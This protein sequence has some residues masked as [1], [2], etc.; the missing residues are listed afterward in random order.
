MIFLLFAVVLVLSANNSGN[1]RK[2]K[3]SPP[4]LSDNIDKNPF[5]RNNI[6]LPVLSDN[7]N[8]NLFLEDRAT[9]L[10]ENWSNPFLSYT[11]R[12]TLSPSS[13]NN[14]RSQDTS[15]YKNAVETT[16]PHSVSVA[17][18][19]NNPF[20][21][22][23][24]N[25]DKNV[26]RMVP[27]INSNSSTSPWNEKLSTPNEIFN[28][29]TAYTIAERKSEQ[30]CQE[31]GR[32]IS[33]TTGILPL[34][35][36]NQ[37][38]IKVTN[39]NCINTNRL[40]IGGVTA[41]PGEFPHMVALGIKYSDGTFHVSC[42]GTLIA[43]EWVLSAAHCTYQPNP[44]DARIGFHD[45]RDNQHG[46]TTTISKMIRHP[47]YKPPTIYNDIALIKLSTVITFNKDI[48]PACLYQEYDIVP[49]QAWVSGWGVTEFEAEER[50]NQLQKA[51]LDIIDNLR[52]AIRHTQSIKIPYGITP[53][54]ICA[55]DPRGGWS[56]DTCQ[57][58]SGGPLQIVHPTNLCLFQILGITS[59]GQGCAF[60]NMPG[61]YT[62]VP[63]YLNWIEDIVW[64][65]A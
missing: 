9:T 53:S 48:R 11:A 6:K 43:P 55:G 54:M 52:C 17:S 44:T 29:T 39:Q 34:V 23:A 25:A 1:S 35:G 15:V 56:K 42:G 36:A 12:S 13:N 60:V 32:Q 18:Y 40:V 2:K 63:H 58:D 24:L 27:E 26:V 41:L 3:P 46:V 5:L 7:I 28:T 38:V 33:S 8:N 16:E 62:R 57:G 10:T 59:F 50:S 19:N 4:K 31:Y 47:S 61:V 30:M 49:E 37:E 45:L 22:A 20:L 51:Q 21:R 14:K 65:K 64:P